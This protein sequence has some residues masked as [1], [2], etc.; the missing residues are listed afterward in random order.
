MPGMKKQYR[1]LSSTLI[2]LFST[3]LVAG[4]SQEKTSDNAPGVSQNTTI[5]NAKT[6][7]NGTDNNKISM[8]DAKSGQLAI[9]EKR[10]IG[11][12]KCVRAA[13]ANFAMDS[14]GE[15]ATVLSQDNSAGTAVKNAINLCPAEAISLS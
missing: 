3:A 2:L 6:G 4:C 1:K 10:C 13:D 14:Q 15:K 11:C 5:A 12:G 7:G 9:D 8:P